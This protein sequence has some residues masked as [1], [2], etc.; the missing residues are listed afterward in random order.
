M[1]KILI[2]FFS[3]SWM[4]L[5][6]Q[7]KPNIYDPLADAGEE[8]QMA[9]KQAASED[10]NVLLMVG[11]NWCP[12]CVRLHGFMLE[13]SAIDSTLQSNYV[14]VKVNYSKENKN[15]DLLK[16]LQFPQ[17]MGFPVMVIL[18]REGNR[19]HTQNTWYLEKEKSYDRDKILSF[20]KDWGPAALDINNYKDYQ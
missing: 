16:Q 11:G 13:D 1:K 10:K 3:V 12:W 5:Q 20:L 15:L 2:F 14:W 9:I 18:D 4:M 6:A 17:R 19:L 8:V 7:E